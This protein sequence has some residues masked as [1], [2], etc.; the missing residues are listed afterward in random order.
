MG[1]LFFRTENISLYR[2]R[3]LRSNPCLLINVPVVGSQ[4]TSALE[5]KLVRMTVRDAAEF[6]ATLIQN[7]KSV[8]GRC[9]ML[10]PFQNREP[11]NRGFLFF[12]WKT[13]SVMR[14]NPNEGNSS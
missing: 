9:Q 3:K 10:G 14:L 11:L 8:L 7:I 1:S 2:N 12:A 5:S 13:C 4:F 6:G